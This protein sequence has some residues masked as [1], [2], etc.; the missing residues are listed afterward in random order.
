MEKL[1]KSYET[2][3]PG[4]AIQNKVLTLANNSHQYRNVEI[5]SDVFNLID[6]TSLNTEDSETSIK[7]MIE[8]VNQFSKHFPD[9]KKVAAVCVFPNFVKTVR[10]TLTDEDIKVAAVGAGFPSSQTF[11][12]IKEEECRMAVE[13]GADEVDIVLSVGEFQDGN[14]E[15]AFEEI[16][17][18]KA[19]VGN[20]HLKVI[21][22]TGSLAVF[23]QIWKASILAMEAGADFIKTS[24]GKQQPAATPEAV[25]IMV[26][27]IKAYHEKTGRMVGIKP[28]GGIG[29]AEDAL[30]YYAIVREVLGEKWI[31]NHFFRIGAS[32]LANHLLSTIKDENVGYF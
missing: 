29:Y 30:T 6:L 7:S 22:E 24:T 2:A 13:A 31:N 27:A 19:A 28:A 20:K 32:R 8:K 3:F 18:L 14:Y 12:K 1:F 21:L 16:K 11:L 4:N 5:L 23:E 9:N 10:S 25:Y 15:K 26:H 17:A